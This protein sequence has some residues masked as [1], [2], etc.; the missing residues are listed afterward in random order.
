[1][2]TIGERITQLRKKKGLTQNQVAEQVGISKA[3]M[4]RY[5]SKGV[6][7]PANTLAK[8]ADVLEVSSDFLL[9]GNANDKAANSL[10]HA[11]V[12]QQYKEVDRLPKEERA[13]IIR[14]IA[15][16]LRDYKTRQA[17]A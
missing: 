6:Q 2:N 14:V 13:T 5:I 3:Q 15:A 8:L 4:S 9:N 10:S 17:Y 7:P 16:L 1:M 11:E 12:I